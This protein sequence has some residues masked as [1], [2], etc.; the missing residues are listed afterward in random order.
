MEIRA[1][2]LAA[3]LFLAGI[4][5][6]LLLE[7]LKELG[8]R[9]FFLVALLV[10]GWL[11]VRGRLMLDVLW[12][13]S[14]ALLTAASLVGFV[15]FG[16]ELNPF[17]DKQPGVQFLA[18]AM[19]FVIGFS[20]L[21]LRLGLRLQEETLLRA[22]RWAL[23]AHLA[24]AAVDQM[25][26]LMDRA[27]PFEGSFL[28]SV[29]RAFPTGL[30][31]EPSYFS[32]YVAMLLPIVLLRA[33]VW[34]IA[35]VSAAAGA[36]FYMGD[37][38]SFFV[39]YGLEM[40]AMIAIRWG[41]RLRTFAVFAVLL[42][43]LGALSS[44]LNLLSVEDSLSSAYRLGN[45]FSYLDHALP[46]DLLVG[47]GFGSSHFL[48]LSLDH[49]AFMILSTE[50]AAMLDGTGM[51]VPVFNLWVRLFVE[52]GVLPT[53]LLL[54]ALLRRTISADVPSS[55]RLLMVG[56]VVFSMSTDSYIYGMFSIA[57]T[58]VYALRIEGAGAPRA[59][60]GR[61][62]AESGHPTPGVA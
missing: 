16:S 31:S 57:L 27:R 18:H 10:L 20:P 4:D 17:G 15:W 23:L 25:A 36:F 9:P 51:R 60:P 5:G 49:P 29:G 19:L 55:A 38:R 22:C 41:L 53:L 21:M 6:F 54:W 8:A 26:I 14:L 50:Y 40:L 48:Y 56:T 33:P 44:E 3:L 35:T 59:L 1:S 11:A 32:A 28:G 37:V 12:A 34:W 42:A 46:H 30:F 7:P 52:I 39:V 43:A 24:F 61:R 45:T 58:L 47:D 13:R 2:H 62:S